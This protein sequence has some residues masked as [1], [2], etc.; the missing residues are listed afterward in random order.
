[1]LLDGLQRPPELK[2][3]LSGVPPREVTNR[4][5]SRYFTSNVMSLGMDLLSPVI[6]RRMSNLAAYSSHS[7][8]AD[9]R[10]RGRLGQNHSLMV[11]LVADMNSITAFG[12]TGNKFYLPGWPSSTGY[13]QWDP[14]YF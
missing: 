2:A 5:V 6:T 11:A 12:M 8:C 3:I 1:M 10:E 14:S 4:L 13:W 9:F 7:S